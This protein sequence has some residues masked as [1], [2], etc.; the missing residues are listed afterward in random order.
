MSELIATNVDNNNCDLT[1][2]TPD[3]VVI[4][5][6]PY[7]SENKDPFK[8][9]NGQIVY[10][11]KNIEPIIKVFQKYKEVPNEDKNRC[12]KYKFCKYVNLPE[13][14]YVF[15]PVDKSCENVI[16]DRKILLKEITIDNNIKQYTLYVDTPPPTSASGGRRTRKRRS[17]KSRKSRRPRRPRKSRR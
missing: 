4:K 14:H 16:F 11:L 1:K 10:I 6:A 3:S 15:K 12:I 13:Q 17:K 5:A 2:I 9:V 8:F 7:N